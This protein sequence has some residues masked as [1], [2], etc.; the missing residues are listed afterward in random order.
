[1]LG[2][3]GDEKSDADGCAGTERNDGGTTHRAS[4]RLGVELGRDSRR[5]PERIDDMFHRSVAVVAIS[6]AAHGSVVE[7]VANLGKYPRSGMTPDPQ[8]RGKLADVLVDRVHA[9]RTPR[10]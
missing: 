9:G 6:H 8:M 5:R 2:S 10:T 4:S 3:S 1:M 7:M